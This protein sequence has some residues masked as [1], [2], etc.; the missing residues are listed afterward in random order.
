[1]H[2]F[3]DLINQFPKDKKSKSKNNSRPPTPKIETEEIK[4]EDSTE[5]AKNLLPA[6]EE[7]IEETAPRKAAE[8]KDELKSDKKAESENETTENE[9]LDKNQDDKN[10]SEKNKEDSLI[11][12]E[13]PDDYLLYLEHILVKIHQTFYEEYESTKQVIDLHITSDSTK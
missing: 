1:M 5:D 13:D 3:S 10:D 9:S 12:I 6:G 4:P 7:S 8:E 2:P 11:E